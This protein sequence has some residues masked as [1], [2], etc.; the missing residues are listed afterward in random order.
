[1]SDGPPRVRTQPRPVIERR[2]ALSKLMK[3]EKT[4]PRVCR[5]SKTTPHAE[6]KKEAAR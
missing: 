3:A 6:G 5:F 4:T 2:G 1:M